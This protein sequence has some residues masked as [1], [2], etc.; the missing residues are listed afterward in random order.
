ME[1]LLTVTEIAEILGV[2]V[3]T[4]YQWTHQEY[5]PHIK[6]GGL[7]RFRIAD[8]MNWLDKR[9]I[10]GRTAKLKRMI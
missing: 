8:I 5:I 2:K 7:L 9:T 10:G 1:K 6:I 4:I 3:S